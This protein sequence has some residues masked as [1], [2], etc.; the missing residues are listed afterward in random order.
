MHNQI[1][2]LLLISLKHS[3]Q[4]YNIKSKMSYRRICSSE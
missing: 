2:D 1:L 3:R 4:D